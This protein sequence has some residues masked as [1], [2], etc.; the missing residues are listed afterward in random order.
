MPPPIDHEKN[1]A[2]MMEDLLLQKR[3]SIISGFIKTPQGEK[4][5]DSIGEFQLKLLINNDE[6]L[7]YE[8]AIP[9]ANLYEKDVTPNKKTLTIGFNINGFKMS[10]S[11]PERGTGNGFPPGGGRRPGGSGGMGGGMPGGRGEMG[12]GPHGGHGQGMPPQN[13]MRGQMDALSKETKLKFKV[14]LVN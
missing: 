5:L 9:L 12:G 3:E 13:G 7:V 1:R 6:S 10:D 2:I 8:A 4:A 11:K 14:E